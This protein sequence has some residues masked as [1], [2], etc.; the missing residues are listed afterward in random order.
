M[1]RAGEGL[2][3]RQAIPEGRVFSYFNGLRIHLTRCPPWSPATCTCRDLQGLASDYRVAL[4]AELHL[5]IPDHQ[6]S[7][8]AYRSLSSRHFNLPGLIQPH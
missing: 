8:Q 3:A 4:R 7:L 1:A 5:Y 2:Y 6:T